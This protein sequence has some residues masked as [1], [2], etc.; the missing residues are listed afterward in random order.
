MNYLNYSLQKI[1]TQ[2]VSNIV[3]YCVDGSNSGQWAL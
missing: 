1:V 2:A 3:L